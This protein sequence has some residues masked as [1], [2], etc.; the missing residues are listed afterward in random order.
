MSMTNS[1]ISEGLLRA[2]L[3]LAPCLV[4]MSVSGIAGLAE[5]TGRVYVY[6]SLGGENK[7]ALFEMNPQTGQLTSQR[8]IPLE[9]SPGS[10]AVDSTRKFLYAAIRSANS[11]ASFRIDPQTGGLDHL[12]TVPVVDNPVYVTPDKKG[13]FLLTS[14][15]GG[16]KA[17]VYPIGKNGAVVGEATAICSTDRNPHSIMVDPSNRFVYVPNTGAD[18]ILQ[19]A[20]NEQTGALSLLS[21]PEVATASGTGPRHIFFHPTKNYVYFVNEK[22]S[23]VTGFHQDRMTGKLKEFQ[24]ISTLPSDFS[25]ENS[26]ADVE[27]TPN[28]KFLYASNRGHDSIAGYSIDLST[29]RLTSLGQQPTEKTPREFNIDPTGNY[30][31]SAGESSGRMASYQINAST[32]QLKPLKI[33]DVGKVPS[34]VL[35]VSLPAPSAEQ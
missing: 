17:A 24:T 12:G 11:V 29:G 10:L 32:G 25:D 21:T 20:F 28:G 15:Y 23:S 1:S 31:Y 9:G 34:W 26:C 22:G 14:Y 13:R 3:L 6:V 35:L 16:G 4:L 27:I 5:K 2:L 30:L 7:I 33:Y 19:Y 18:K 8:N